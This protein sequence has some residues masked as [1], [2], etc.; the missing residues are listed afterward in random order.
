MING[1]SNVIYPIF[2]E[3]K[4][5][6]IQASILKQIF[7]TLSRK[8]LYSTFFLDKKSG[9]KKSIRFE[10]EELDFRRFPKRIGIRKYS[11]SV[12]LY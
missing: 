6:T 4:L 3:Y 5:S 12:G 7:F 11:K 10:S 2:F 9:A 8:T 1:R